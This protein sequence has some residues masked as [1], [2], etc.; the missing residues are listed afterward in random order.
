L[1]LMNTVKSIFLSLVIVA[2]FAAAGCGSSSDHENNT[3]HHHPH[4]DTVK[5]GGA[6]DT[7]RVSG[8][9]ETESYS[10]IVPCADCDG[11]ETIIALKSDSTY[12]MRH[13]YMGRK[14]TGPGSNEI[15]YSGRWMKHGPEMV[16]LTG[17]KDAPSM[18]IRTDSS[19]IQLDMK[20]ERITGKLAGKYELKKQK[21]IGQ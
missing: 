14:S 21:S 16:H 10:G 19:L 9:V 15:S 18:Y 12:S 11:I 20:G 8:V 6:E 4:G 3:D 17:I 2:G 5:T 7:S 1:I 13:L